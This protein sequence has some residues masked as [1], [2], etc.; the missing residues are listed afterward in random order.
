[1]ADGLEIL[2]RIVHP[3]ERVQIDYNIAKLY[4]HTPID[5]PVIISRGLKPGPILG[6]IAGIH[7]DEFNG[8]EIVRRMVRNKMLDPVR[9]TVI[10][11]PVVNV[12]GFLDQAREFP[13]AKDLNRSFPGSR[14]GSLAARTAHFIAAEI[15]PVIDLGIDFHTGGNALSNYPHVRVHFN[16]EEHLSVARAFNSRFIVQSGLLDKSLRKTAWNMGKTMLVYEGGKTLEYDELSIVQG[17]EGTMSVM[18]HL[19]MR[20]KPKGIPKRRSQFL[21]DT[22]WVRAPL[23]GM[24]Q[25]VV[26]N[27][28][29]VKVNE[30]IAIISDPFGTMEYKVKSHIA[31]YVF[32]VNESPVVNQG[33]PIIHIGV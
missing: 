3:G 17:I 13:G 5:I 31:G 18:S 28:G 2:G 24:M 23:S 26:K 29:R 30:T 33:D 27:G 9:G 10:A 8:V 25:I 12:F 11:I 21:Q 15:L 1:M 22:K 32:G 4:T 16:D 6:V 7:G 19:G 14:N 20:P